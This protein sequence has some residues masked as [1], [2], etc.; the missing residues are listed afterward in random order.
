MT[1]YHPKKL[2]F[3]IASL[4]FLGLIVIGVS[5][6]IGETWLDFSLLKNSDS[7]ERQILWLRLNRAL[8]AFLV[9]ATLG[10]SGACFQSLL[11]NPLAD[12]YILGVSGGA[13][14]GMVFGGFIGLGFWMQ[15]SLAFFFS[16]VSLVLIFGLARKNGGLA[17]DRLLLTGVIY[18]AFCFALI[19]FLLSLSSFGQTNTAF[20]ILLGSLKA[21]QLEFLLPLSALLVFCFWFLLKK[22]HALN[23]MTLGEEESQLLGVQTT[24]LRQATFVITSIMVGVSVCLAGLIGYVGLFIPH[25]M[26]LTWGVDHRL[27][28]PT[29]ILCGGIFLVFC[30]W[31]SRMGFLLGVLNTQ[32]PIGIITALIGAPFFV[33]FISRKT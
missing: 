22:S 20:S 6:F 13:A 30:D 11:K 9:G 4:T 32:L 29:S 3:A 2:A 24:Q 10:F 21:R 12:P 33:Y 31:L 14:L 18:N 16:F 19:F 7:I 25:L 1:L 23:L 15:N 27:V 28:L 26:R 5:V 8:I 17:N